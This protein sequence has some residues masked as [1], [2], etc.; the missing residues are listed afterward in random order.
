[1]LV[2]ASFTPSAWAQ[3]PSDDERARGH[4]EAAHSYHADGDY[5]RALEEFERAYELS[6]RVLLLV[7]I[8]NCEERLGMW[9]EAADHLAAYVATLPPDTEEVATLN[10]RIGHLRERAARGASREEP[11]LPDGPPLPDADAVDASAVEPP[12]AEPSAASGS[13]GLLVPSLIT[14]GVSAALGITW[15]TLG[16]LALAERDSIAA[17]CGATRTCSG[18]RVGT[19]EGL[20]IGA[21]VSMALTLVAAATGLVLLLVDPPRGGA[22]ELAVLPVLGPD[23]AALVLGGVL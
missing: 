21:D 7:N 17:E 20:A 10:R 19:L 13:D 1:M 23:G 3:G 4:F 9:G 8:A 15:A 22:S 16:G 11:P 18:E 5:E 2:L 14:L 6:G 12:A